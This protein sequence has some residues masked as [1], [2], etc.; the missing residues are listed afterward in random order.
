M[1]K[2]P[3]ANAGDAGLIPRSGRPPGG[4]HGNHSSILA[5]KIPWTE[6][7][8][9]LGYSPSCHK[10]L[11]TAEAIEHARMQAFNKMLV[12]F[13][14]IPICICFYNKVITY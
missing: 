2:N 11:D 6:E 14:P 1:V 3:P 5:G 9:R 8:G 13:L 10:E 4:E 7:P 12:S